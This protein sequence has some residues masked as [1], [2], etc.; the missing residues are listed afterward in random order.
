MSK[1]A[2]ESARKTAARLARAV[3][4]PRLVRVHRSIRGADRLD[5]LVLGTSPAWTL[6]AVCEDLRPD[7]FTAVR[8]PDITRV[9][10]LGDEDSLTL[11]VLRRRGQWPVH[12]ALD[13]STSPGLVRDAAAHHPLLAFH[14][15]TRD[16]D[17]CW[18]GRPV[19]YRAKSCGVLEVDPEARWSPT[20]S[21]YRFKHLTRIDFGGHYL[22]TLAEFAAA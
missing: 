11:R 1:T 14:E 17:V 13:L 22:R 21:T 3:G 4:A 18:V 8:T 9:R 19:G 15:E 16:P 20:P 5:G 10:R 2:E 6:L 12:P 7:G